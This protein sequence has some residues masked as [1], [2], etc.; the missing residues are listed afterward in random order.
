MAGVLSL[1][2]LGSWLQLKWRLQSNTLQHFNDDGEF[3]TFTG[4]I[5]GEPD[6]RETKT[7]YSVQIHTVDDQTTSGRALVEGSRLS[8][9]E[10]YDEI[11]IKGE[12]ILPPESKDFSYKNYLLLQEIQSIVPDARISLSR[13]YE[14]WSLRK[15]LL[16][17]KR[18]FEWN[19][20]RIF[21]EP[22]ASFMAGIIL[23]SRRGIPQD[24][25]EQFSITGLTHILAISGY[26]ITIIIVLVTQV[27]AFLPR[28]LSY[29]IAIAV[30]ILFTILV[31]ASAAVVRASI[32]G[33]IGLIAR[34]HGRQTLAL[35]TIVLT[36]SLMIIYNPLIIF[37]DAGFQ[38]SF[39]AVIGIIYISPYLEQKLEW[40]PEK[41]MIRESLTITL[42][43]Q[44]TAVP[45]IVYLFGTLSL[46]S[47][48]A[49]VLIAPFLPAAMLFGFLAG[50]S[51]FVSEPP[52]YVI[53][54][55]GNGILEIALTLIE[56][57]SQ[58]P[59]ALLD[60]S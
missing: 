42:A 14:N 33:I 56:L 7:N 55:I 18:S 38:L 45:L 54:F 21:P 30:I 20:N 26:N 23:G 48:L 9:F 46:V 24:L 34:N 6:K 40:V 25:M 28:K 49:N 41:C 58:V 27:L 11:K 52:G 22:Q 19:L 37:Y 15:W 13:S 1:L 10:L 59:Y 12:L 57:C 50:T 43:A 51:Y 39:L 29:Q 31:G 2:M 47:P 8:Q 53:G 5:I 16:E 32:M 3:H 35:T 36:A 17:L 4:T 60:V 44:S